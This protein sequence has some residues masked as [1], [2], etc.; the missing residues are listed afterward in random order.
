VAEAQFHHGLVLLT[1]AL[2]AIA[3][4]VLMRVNAP[5]G[6]FG[7]AGWGPTIPARRAWVIFE[8]PAVLAF[9]LIYF[10]GDRA[11]QLA[12]L[13]FFGIWQLHYIA[14]TFFFPLRM[15]VPARPIPIVVV[16]LAFVFNLLNAYINARWISHLAAYPDRWLSSPPFLVGVAL[17]L[18]GWVINQRADLALSRLRKPGGPRYSIPQGGLYRYISCPNYFGEILEW[19]GWAVLTW[20]LA[21]TAF[22]V[23]TAANLLPRA[24]ATHRWYRDTFPDYPRDRKAVLPF[25]V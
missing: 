21:G 14:R 17:F 13:A 23:F 8:S 20:S 6:R 7:R 12:P 4:V 22:A 19:I 24:I 5:Y 2:A 18:A 11:L 10:A 1:F 25:L 3:F 15:R 9:A 16:A